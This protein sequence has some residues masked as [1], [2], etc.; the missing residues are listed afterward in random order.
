[1]Y[2]IFF[3]NTKQPDRK[4]NCSHFETKSFSLAIFYA[5]TKTPHGE[6]NCSL[7]KAKAFSKLFL[8]GSHSL[9]IDKKSTRQE[10]LLLSLCWKQNLFTCMSDIFFAITKNPH[11]KK[12]CSLVFRWKQN[13]FTCMS[14]IFF[15]ITK[16]PHGEKNCVAL[17]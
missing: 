6:K 4:K 13:L 7:P 1:M 12:N 5:N 2:S 9:W 14:D 16:N 10:E 11:G 17:Y 15:A 8:F 3:A